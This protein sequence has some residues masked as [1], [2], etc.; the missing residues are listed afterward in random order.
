MFFRRQQNESHHKNSHDRNP[1]SQPQSPDPPQNPEAVENLT[2][3]VADLQ[4]QLQEAMQKTVDDF[5][6]FIHE[7]SGWVLE[8]VLKVFVNVGHYKPLKG[9]FYIPLPKGLTGR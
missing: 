9:K 4:D 8:K 2:P 7:G 6:N 5:E 1:D 3:H